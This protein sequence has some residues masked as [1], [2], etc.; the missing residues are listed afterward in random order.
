M[1]DVWLSF[2]LALALEFW[3][4]WFCRFSHLFL[5]LQGIHA[6]GLVRVPDCFFPIDV[7]PQPTP[8]T[9][10]R[11]TRQFKWIVSWPVGGAIPTGQGEGSL[12]G[13]CE[14]KVGE[15]A[16]RESPNPCLP[17][18]GYRRKCLGNLGLM[19]ACSEPLH[20]TDLKCGQP[21]RRLLSCGGGT[22]ARMT[23]ANCFLTE[24][25]LQAGA[26][27]CSEQES[28]MPFP[29]RKEFQETSSKVEQSYW[30]KCTEWCV[31]GEKE[32]VFKRKQGLFQNGKKKKQNTSQVGMCS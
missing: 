5:C 26:K 23:P 10:N 12:C 22:E 9:Y 15:A 3:S 16:S 17:P 19:I 7:T 1:G 31:R 25:G 20:R 18:L 13:V 6:F 29:Q 21:R 8:P 27:T 30:K 24:M 32:N 11:L 14:V 2:S 28:P 4:Q